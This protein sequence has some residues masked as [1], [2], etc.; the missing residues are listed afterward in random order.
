MYYPHTGKKSLSEGDED[1]W[2]L[3]VF[4]ENYHCLKK[5]SEMYLCLLSLVQKA[6]PLVS[7]DG[8]GK[9]TVK[10]LKGHIFFGRRWKHWL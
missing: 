5:A 6:F 9:C 4:W 2:S 10:D 7:K 1:P 3:G 8:G